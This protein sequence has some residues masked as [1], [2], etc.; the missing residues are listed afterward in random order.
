VIF[1]LLGLQRTFS[2]LVVRLRRVRL[3]FG[4]VSGGSGNTSFV[5]YFTMS[6]PV[7]CID[8]LDEFPE[9]GKGVKLIMMDHVIFDTF[10]KSI[11]NLPAECCL[12]P[13]NA[14]G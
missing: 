10:G 2:R 13:L 6:F 11:V 7:S 1:L 4:L 9:A 5:G 14:C 3:L 12:A 8:S